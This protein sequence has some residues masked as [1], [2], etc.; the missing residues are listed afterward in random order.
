MAKWGI[1]ND[2][3]VCKLDVSCNE[4]IFLQGISGK[5]DFSYLI[6][7]KFEKNKTAPDIV[8]EDRGGANL[9]HGNYE[10]LPDSKIIR[11]LAK[12]DG[13]VTVVRNG[14]VR[15]IHKIRAGEVLIIG[16]LTFGTKINI[17]QGK[18]LVRTVAFER[19]KKPNSNSEN[20]RILQK[21]LSACRGNVIT[22]HHSM[23]SMI[24]KLS[25]Y[26][27]TREWLLKM[28]QRGEISRTAF[29]MLLRF[30]MQVARRI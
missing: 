18:D 22:L 30:I 8:I 4:S 6:R 5:L 11:V 28:V 16:E 23:G 13:K 14:K 9:S 12:F 1:I 25:G 2:G 3:V 10:K 17:F 29:K 27:I 26:P 21:R 19:K 20:D 15:S 24:G 7:K